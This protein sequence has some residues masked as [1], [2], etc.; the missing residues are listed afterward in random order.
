MKTNDAFQFSITICFPGTDEV[1]NPWEFLPG[2][3]YGSRSRK[4]GIGWDY[5]WGGKAVQALVELSTN[6]KLTKY[7]TMS[8]DLGK[9]SG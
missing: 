5:K 6:V 4:P 2:I 9:T 3:P 7:F 8:H 1:E